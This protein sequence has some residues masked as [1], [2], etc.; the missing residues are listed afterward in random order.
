MDQLVVSGLDVAWVDT[1]VNPAFVVPLT[2][3]D[4]EVRGLST[5][6]AL[7]PV[8]MRF[9]AVL[10][11]APVRLTQVDHGSSSAP[12]DPNARAE[13]TRALFQEV[14][15]VGRLT[16]GPSPSGWIKAGIS[17]L[18]L[19]A[20]SG[21]A[22]AYGVTLRDGVLDAGLNVR[23][24]DGKAQTRV[25]VVLT[26]LSMAEMTEGP[27]AQACI[28]LYPWTRRC[29]SCEDR[30]GPSGCPCDLRSRTRA[31]PEGR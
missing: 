21:L 13:E 18:E 7:D 6:A 19:R 14:T 9:G 3:L 29:S 30:T 25:D 24:A 1:T 23:L 16:G 4:L 20:F 27:M 5:R 11:S 2:G 12:Q 15:A 8:P 22:R 31:C 10:T 28:C 26:D 17:G